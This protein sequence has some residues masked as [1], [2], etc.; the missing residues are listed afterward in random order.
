M[1]GDTNA[2]KLVVSNQL[3]IPDYLLELLSISDKE[4]N[5]VAFGPSLTFSFDILTG[6]TKVE[7]GQSDDPSTIFTKLLVRKTRDFEN[8]QPPGYYPSYFEF[9]PEQRWVYLNWLRD[10]TQPIDIGYVFVFYYGL[11]RHLILG[12]FDLA[13]DEI[14][15]LRQHHENSSFESYSSV[16]LA[17][18]AIF[19]RRIDRL[20]QFYEIEEGNVYG[21]IEL[22][23]AYF[24]RLDLSVEQLVNVA[25]QIKEI[26][27]RYYKLHPEIFWSKLEAKLVDKYGTEEFPFASNTQID[28]KK[29]P[30]RTELVFA[31]YSLPHET[32]QANAPSFLDYPPFKKEVRELFSELH[33]EIKH[34]LKEQRKK[35]K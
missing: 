24:S 30:T 11:E 1:T 8:I 35:N 6:E 17:Y 15:K 19:R 18:S 21:N 9:S 33:E 3:Q 22:L 2:N 29:L 14:L 25:K 26:N 5:K 10:V 13:F 7:E 12:E 31:N 16:A 4:P 28:L 32:R 20:Q 27:W 34:Y 23:L